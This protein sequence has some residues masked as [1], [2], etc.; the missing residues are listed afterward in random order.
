MTPAG[1]ASARTSP[2]RAASDAIHQRCSL[3]IAHRTVLAARARMRLVERQP[4]RVWRNSSQAAGFD[5]RSR[6][7]AGV[8]VACVRAGE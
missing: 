6:A 8:T 5:C 3:D 4:S 7:V 1:H 2:P